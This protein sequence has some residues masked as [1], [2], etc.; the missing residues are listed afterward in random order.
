MSGNDAAIFLSVI[1]GAS[2]LMGYIA[3]RVIMSLFRRVVRD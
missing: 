1:G 2:L 3:I